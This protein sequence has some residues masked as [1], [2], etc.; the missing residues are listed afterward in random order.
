VRL[1][2]RHVF[3]YCSFVGIGAN[4]APC[5]NTQADESRLSLIFG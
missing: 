5:V 1:Q 2:V 4:H 3:S